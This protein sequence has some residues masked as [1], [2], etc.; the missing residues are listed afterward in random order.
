MLMGWFSRVAFPAVAACVLAGA[1]PALAQ[2][3]GTTVPLFPTIMVPMFPG[4]N[5]VPFS[6]QSS[7]G[8]SHAGTGTVSPATILIVPG[9]SGLDASA[10][11]L[12]S[13]FPPNAQPRMKAAYLQSFDAFRKF[14]RKLDLPDNDVANGVSAYIAGNYMVLHGAEIEDAAFLK[15]VSQVRQGLLQSRG[16]RQV[17]AAQK[18]KL[19]EQTAM[20]GMFMAVAQLSAKT[21]PQD[22]NVQRNL[23]DSA[24]ANLALILGESASRLRIDDAG[25]HL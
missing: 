14:E 6:G 15:L 25:M 2:Y 10:A 4:G 24:R 23:Q 17:S 5:T 20:V 11:D 7:G 13:H 9:P 3:V 1:S 21:S 16:F 19:F 18:R 8:R 12:A 22:P